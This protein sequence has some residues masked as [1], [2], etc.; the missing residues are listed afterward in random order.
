MATGPCAWFR[1]C[2][3]KIK[4]PK[5]TPLTACSTTT[6]AAAALRL[7]PPQVRPHPSLH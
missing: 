7:A 4:Q 6:A 1:L 5:R 2:Q 3:G